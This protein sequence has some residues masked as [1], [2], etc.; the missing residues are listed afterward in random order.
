[1]ANLAATNLAATNLVVTR[2]AAVIRARKI[3]AASLADSNRAVRHSEASTIAPPETSTSSAP[4]S[5]AEEP[6]LLPENLWP[7]IVASP[8]L[9][10]ASCG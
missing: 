5:V 3:A 8:P 9:L 7:S 1:V 10:S 4:G 2:T 6:I